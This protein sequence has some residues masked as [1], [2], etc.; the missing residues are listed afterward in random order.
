MH[1]YIHYMHA[2]HLTTCIDTVHYFFIIFA[3]NDYLLSKMFR[4]EGSFYIYHKIFI[5]W[6]FPGGSMVKNLSANARGS[7]S[8]PG[9]GRCPGGGNGNPLQ[10]FCLENSM[11]RGSWCAAV[12]GVPR[13]RYDWAHTHLP[14][15]TFSIPLVPSF[16]HTVKGYFLSA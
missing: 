4:W 14:I 1:F 3:L 5:I 12:H 11:N 8:I 2:L 10:Y 6:G 7:D 9:L 15:T 16:G 13:V